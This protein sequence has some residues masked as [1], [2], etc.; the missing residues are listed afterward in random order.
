MALSVSGFDSAFDHKI[1]YE[2]AASETANEDVAQGACTL[3]SV[4]IDNSN[5]TST[6][7]LKIFDGDFVSAAASTA[8]TILECANAATQIYD[9]P[10]GLPFSKLNFW[11]T[12]NAAS[13]DTT[14]PAVSG[15]TVA[16][17]LVV[18]K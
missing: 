3:L 1:V 8:Q 14:A 16:V 18:R 15:G 9:L 10:D 13:N 4:E 7:Y 5:G 6:P 11:L 12:R 17:R 2:S